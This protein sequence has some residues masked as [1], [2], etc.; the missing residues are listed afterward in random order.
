MDTKEHIKK[1][2]DLIGA[3]PVTGDNVDIMCAARQELRT[4]YNA[5]AAAEKAKA[6]EAADNG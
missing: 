4:A 2:F 3:I 1:A 5:L 6:K